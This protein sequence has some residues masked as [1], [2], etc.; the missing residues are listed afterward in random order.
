M[1]LFANIIW[2]LCGGFLVALAYYMFGGLMLL[3]VIGAPI[4]LGLI[5]LGHF[6]WAPFGKAMVPSA[7]VGK[8]KHSAR[9]VWNVAIG[10]IWLP[11]GLF[12]AT[13]SLLQIAICFITII[14]I[15]V[16]MAVAKSLPSI[17]W[18]AGKVCRRQAVADEIARRKDAAELAMMD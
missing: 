2:H 4:G 3:T 16:G 14:G 9:K 13:V 1:R 7:A 15:P 8:E 18:P 10:V 11:F 17:I 5:Q 12:M 6:C